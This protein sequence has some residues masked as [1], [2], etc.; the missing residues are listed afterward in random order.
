ML[1]SV[2]N[3]FHERGKRTS[4]LC[5][6]FLSPTAKEIC[7][8]RQSHI[9]LTYIEG[10][11]QQ[12]QRPRWAR[13]SVLLK[14]ESSL[15]GREARRRIL[16]PPAAP[17]PA[18]RGVPERA[19]RPPQLRWLVS[20]LLA[21]GLPATLAPAPGSVCEGGGTPSWRPGRKENRT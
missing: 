1:L 7:K 3:E 18:R 5:V 2:K 16:C 9:K 10:T 6:L 15:E 19:L 13:R 12:V 8:E 20:P 17:A 11:P 14:R 4:L 21:P